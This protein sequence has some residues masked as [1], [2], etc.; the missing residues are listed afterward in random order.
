MEDD[1]T[2]VTDVFENEFF[3]LI[4]ISSEFVPNST[5][6]DPLSERQNLDRRIVQNLTLFV[7]FSVVAALSLLIN[8]RVFYIVFVT[9]K[10]KSRYKLLTQSLLNVALKNMTF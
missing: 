9:S 10:R 1:N 7:T 3:N 2:I 5:A 6:L 8:L 4:N